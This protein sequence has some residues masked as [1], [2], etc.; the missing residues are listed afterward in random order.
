MLDRFHSPCPCCGKGDI[1]QEVKDGLIALEEVLGHLI[2]LTGPGAGYRCEKHNAEI[3]GSSKNSQ[4]CKGLA[5]DITSEK[6]SVEEIAAA[7]ERISCFHL[8]GIGRYPK[9]YFVH[10]D[11]RKGM[12]SR[13]TA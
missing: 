1:A 13:W 5:A 11:A 2:L 9:H 4:H 8:G 12:Q 7:A 6:A 3:P 10:V